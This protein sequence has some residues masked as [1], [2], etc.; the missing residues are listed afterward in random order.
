MRVHEH[1][2]FLNGKIETKRKKDATHPVVKINDNATL[3]LRQ[4]AVCYHPDTEAHF[5]M[6]RRW[7]KYS[8]CEFTIGGLTGF[9]PGVRWIYREPTKHQM[10]YSKPLKSPGQWRQTGR[11]E[12]YPMYLRAMMRLTAQ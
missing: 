12:K 3:H 8:K 10:Q 5:C 6:T 7:P 9:Y 2:R 11:P 4:Y 1:V